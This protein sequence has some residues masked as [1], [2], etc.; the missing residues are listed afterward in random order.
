M[1]VLPDLRAHFSRF[2]DA[3]PDRLHVAAHSHHPWPD[4]S[5]GAQQRAWLEA[6]RRWDHK[7]ERVM[8]EVVPEARRHV[9]GRLGLPDPGSLAFA[10][11][12]HELVTRVLHSLEPPVRVL[13]TGA[14][15]HSF[16]R[17]I[18]RSEEAG[19]ALVQRVPV[20]PVADFPERFRRAA[21]RTRQDLVVLSH[22]HFDSAYVHPDLEGTV[23]AVDDEA[24]VIVDGYHGFMALPTDLGAL[25]DRVFYVAGGYKYAMAG[26]GACFLHCPPGWL[27]RPVDTGWFAGRAP[28]S[29]RPVTYGRGSDRFWG[30]TFDPT[31][32]ERL[33]AVQRWFDGVGLTVEAVHDHVTALQRRL[34]EGIEQLGSPELGRDSLVGPLT[35]R[36]HFLAIATPRAGRIERELAERGVVCDSRGDR[37]RLGLG[38]Y[39]R[40]ADVDELVARLGAALRGLDGG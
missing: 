2:L 19:R 29:D 37:L 3:V 20:A 17:Q 38:C 10:P 25:A 18:R 24:V 15:F 11:N 8:G 21:H 34:L 36:G 27:P 31:A 23:A 33:N 32:L 26:E 22:V 12:T 30:A 28:A 40:E 13:T 7:W 16:E 9:A 1:S 35:P 4:V 39:H 14:E 5:F 6:A